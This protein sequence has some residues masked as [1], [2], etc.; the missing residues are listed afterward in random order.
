M[1]ELHEIADAGTP[2]RPFFAPGWY[3]SL[4]NTEYHNS[5]G[6]SSS[7][8]KKLCERTG[9]HLK[10][11]QP[12]EQTV[13]MAL[14][15][16]VH[17]LVLEPDQGDQVVCMPE[18][19]LRTK[20]GRAGRD[21]FALMH[22]GRTV[23]N[24]EHY[25]RAHAMAEAI[26]S[27]ETAH[28]LLQDVIAESSVFWWHHNRGEY[29]DPADRLMLK[30]RPDAVSRSHDVVIDLKSCADASYSGFI[31]SVQNYYYHFSAAMYLEGVNQCEP[32]LSATGN[33]EFKKFVF[34]C[35][36]N[37]EPYLVAIYELSPDYLELGRTLFARAV[38]KYIDAQ[39]EGFPG[40]PRDVRV[41]EPPPWARNT[42]IV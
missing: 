23:L 1:N 14:G 11:A 27:H 40:Y 36:E 26:D 2:E 24:A 41:L 25:D 19:N 21:E 3:R 31:R 7:Q 20:A 16:A 13:S 6:V 39:R 10:H 17:T 33:A 32:L 29:T 30:V 12:M 28:T 37:V 35:V 8:L 4:S 42:W 22:R 34:I 5:A 38:T 9:S 15:T 18:F